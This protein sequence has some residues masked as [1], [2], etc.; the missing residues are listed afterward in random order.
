M[1]D[2]KIPV[3]FRSGVCTLK[4]IKLTAYYWVCLDLAMILS[5]FAT[6]FWLLRFLKMWRFFVFLI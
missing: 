6:V 5:L 3:P 2:S 4:M 1:E